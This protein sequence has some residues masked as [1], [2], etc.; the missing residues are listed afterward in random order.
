MLLLLA[1]TAHA[2]VVRTCDPVRVTGTVP[3][4]EQVEVPV[5]TWIAATIAGDCGGSTG[6]TF[7]VA[8]ADGTLVASQA[9]PEDEVLDDGLL[10]FVPDAPLDPDTAY[11]LSITGDGGG[12][13]SAVGF[14]TGDATVTGMSGAPSVTADGYTWSADQHRNTVDWS[15]TAADDP[16]HLSIVQVRDSAD[17]SLPVRSEAVPASGGLD[18]ETVWTGS[19]R[20]A[21]ICLQARQLDATGAIT[22]WSGED[23]VA[24]GCDA[25][26]APASAGATL[27]ALALL[28]RRR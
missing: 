18:A 22:D 24:G 25:V 5:D 8:R 9:F 17:T 1:T 21:R 23:C 11:V 7:A 12:E 2:N 6:Y 27:L 14:T 20:P 16:D 26:G 4:P 15:G 13:E 10:D 19:R 3:A 28:G